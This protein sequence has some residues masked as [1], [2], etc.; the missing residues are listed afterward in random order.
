MNSRVYE[1]VE[2]D[3]RHLL[4]AVD[5]LEAEVEQLVYDKEWYSSDSLDLLLSSKQILHSLLGIVNPEDEDD[6]DLQIPI[7]LR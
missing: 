4:L 6:E 5:T 7:D 3:L 2:A 1:V